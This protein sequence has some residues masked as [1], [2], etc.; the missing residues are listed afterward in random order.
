MAT[1]TIRRTTVDLDVEELD[2]AKQTLGTVTTRETID[3]AL[4]AVNRQA[5]LARAAD[6]IRSG[7]FEVVSPEELA[8]LRRPRI[9]L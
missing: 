1:R 6:V 4:R 8:A 9:E 2:R 5:A 7:D 3:A